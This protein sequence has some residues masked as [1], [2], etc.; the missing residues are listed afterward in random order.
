MPE[1]S[2]VIPVTGTS[3]NFIISGGE[4]MKKRVL[5]ALLAV[6]MVV[7]LGTVSALADN[8]VVMS[9][10]ELIFAADNAR[11]GD[12]ITLG[13]NIVMDPTNV[14]DPASEGL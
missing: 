8:T 12:V 1:I 13:A 2:G 5:T 6:I 9:A 3:T 14:S 4:N 11:D 10:E 7:S